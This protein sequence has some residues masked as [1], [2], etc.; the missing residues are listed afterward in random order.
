MGIFK[1]IITIALVWLVYNLYQRYTSQKNLS[2]DSDNKITDQ[3]MV[4]CEVC[5][6]H[7]PLNEAID[8]NGT[9]FCCT[10][11]QDIFHQ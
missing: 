11:H 6:L 9:Y 7:I 2:S 1:L 8:E 3:K 5:D 4:M 10:E